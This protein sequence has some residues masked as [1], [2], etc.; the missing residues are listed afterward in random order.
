ME[1]INII[2]LQS[3]EKQNVLVNILLLNLLYIKMKKEEKN[4][5]HGINFGIKIFSLESILPLGEANKKTI[6]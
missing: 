3:Q 6:L 2:L 1:Y 5:R 4:L